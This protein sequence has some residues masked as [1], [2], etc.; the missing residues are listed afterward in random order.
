MRTFCAAVCGSK[1]GNGGRGCSSAMSTH[2]FQLLQRAHAKGN[3]HL[4][5]A[6][7]RVFGVADLA[8]VDVAVRVDGE[9]M[10]GD[11]FSGLKSGTR[12]SSQPRDRLALVVDER[13]A[14]ADVGMRAVHGEAGSELADEELRVLSAA[15]EQAAGAVHV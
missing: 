8:D 11:K 7:A 2:F 13:E 5:G 4:V 9:A 15:A 3:R 12:F 14:R 6:E 10:R 1:G